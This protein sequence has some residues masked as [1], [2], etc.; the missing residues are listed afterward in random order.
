MKLKILLEVLKSP[1]SEFTA[2][3]TNASLLQMLLRFLKN[4]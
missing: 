1:F 2:E 4:V 3:E